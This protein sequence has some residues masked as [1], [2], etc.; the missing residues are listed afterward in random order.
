MAEAFVDVKLDEAELERVR[1]VLRDIPGAMPR[2]MSRAVNQTAAMGRTAVVKAVAGATG[3]KAKDVRRRTWLRKASRRYWQAEI[4]IGGKGVPLIRFGA[5]L[6][7]RT[8]AIETTPKQSLYL[9]GQVFGPQ[10]GPAAEFSWR[11]RIRRKATTA[12]VDTGSGREPAT[13]G[14]VATMPSGHRGIFRRTGPR[15]LPI[16]QQYGPS[17]AE[18]FETKL[19]VAPRIELELGETL[20][21]KID[22]QVTYELSRVR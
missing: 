18:L 8:V 9:F 17:I 5:R 11:Y 10:Y 22:A 7:R 2:V 16:K 13:G 15:R 19:G 1:K 14:F 21:R 3:L 4:A 6:R 12:T 20:V